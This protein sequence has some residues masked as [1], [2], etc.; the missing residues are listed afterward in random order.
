MV[1]GFLK[2]ISTTVHKRIL[3]LVWVGNKIISLLY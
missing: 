1:K 2:K 3:F